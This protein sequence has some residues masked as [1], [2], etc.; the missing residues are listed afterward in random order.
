M[1]TTQT[2]NGLDAESRAR[3]EAAD[4]K[5]YVFVSNLADKH[6]TSLYEQ[7]ETAA[8]GAAMRRADLFDLT[9]EQRE[10][11]VEAFASNRA[12]YLFYEIEDEM[13]TDPASWVEVRMVD[14]SAE[15]LRRFGEELLDAA[16]L[17]EA[18]E[19]ERAR[20]ERELIEDEAATA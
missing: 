15:D 9:D 20:R 12:A 14:W 19:E 7:F 13:K 4:E 5:V 18:P 10:M 1:S 2:Q 8:V 6:A 3:A 16:R 11:F 17:A